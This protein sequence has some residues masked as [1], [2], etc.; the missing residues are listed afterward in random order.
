MILLFCVH[1][2]SKCGIDLSLGQFTTYA[3]GIEEKEEKL[4]D[5]KANSLPMSEHVHTLIISV[6]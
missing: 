4:R 1:H 3:A 2:D 5:K 6:A